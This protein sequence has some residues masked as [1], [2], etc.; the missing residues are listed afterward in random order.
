MSDTEATSVTKMAV[1]KWTIR[2]FVLLFQLA[3]IMRYLQ[4]FIF[5]IIYFCVIKLY[6]FFI[7]IT[8]GTSFIK[9]NSLKEIVV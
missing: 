3:P 8:T 9:F 5:K 4:P 1:K 2:I 7:R 6:L